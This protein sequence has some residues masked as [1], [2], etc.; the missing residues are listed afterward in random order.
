MLRPVILSIAMIAVAGASAAQ[1]T[2]DIRARGGRARVLAR[3]GVTNAELVAMLDTYAVVRAQKLLQID[4][5]QYGEFVV[6]LRNLQET[7]RRNRQ[8]RNR[9]LQDLR[10]L[11]A[12]RAG[13]PDENAI[14]ERLQ[15]L[16]AHD[17]RA[18]AAMR[19]A[20][21]SLDEVLSVAQRARFRILEENLERRKLD[22]LV[23]A[24]ERAARRSR[25]GGGS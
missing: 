21:D 3:G 23:R 17:E 9:I 12:P 1:Q 4:D 10:R 7:R 19:R 8:A 18:A 24:R 5:A 2:P 25:R 22:L 16:R 14:R 11:S 20:Y 6:R 13:Q 15:T